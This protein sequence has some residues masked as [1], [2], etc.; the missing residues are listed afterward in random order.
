MARIALLH[1]LGATLSFAI[2]A[3]GCGNGDGGGTG[4]GSGGSSAGSGGAGTASG[5]SPG[6]GGAN[7]GSS[8]GSGGGTDPWTLVACTTQQK[9]ATCTPDQN[10]AK[11]CGPDKTGR[12]GEIC[13]GGLFSD[14]V[15][16]FPMSASYACY[17]L[18]TPLPACPAGTMSGAACTEVACKACGDPV[19]TGFLDSQNTPKRGFCV[20]TNGAWSCSSI[21]GWPCYSST[22]AA[23]SPGC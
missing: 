12:Y 6:S 20:C 15:C 23:L 14:G 13:T 5:G 3:S 11:T 8:G 4:T 7:S 17:K 22:G 21:N 19:G 9:G 2:V 1:V 16:I 18:V 10:C